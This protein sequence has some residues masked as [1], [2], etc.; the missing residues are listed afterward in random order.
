MLKSQNKIL[1][2]SLRLNIWLLASLLL[3]SLS[4][5][6]V[7]YAY[8]QSANQPKSNS[9]SPKTKKP[10]IDESKF[11]E[12][13]RV[14]LEISELKD[15]ESEG[16]IS[17]FT[18]VEL[19]EGSDINQS[20]DN[21]YKLD[22][23][24]FRDPRG[25]GAQFGTF[26]VNPEE[27]F[28]SYKT[29]FVLDENSTNKR[30]HVIEQETERLAEIIKTSSGP[31][32]DGDRMTPA[33]KQ[34]ALDDLAFSIDLGNY[35]TA[36]KHALLRQTF[37]APTNRQKRDSAFRLMIGLNHRGSL[38][39]YKI[40]KHFRDNLYSSCENW[41]VCY[42]ALSHLG[43]IANASPSLILDEEYQAR[44]KS[45][46]EGLNQKDEFVEKMLLYRLSIIT[47][48]AKFME[49]TGLNSRH[50]LGREPT[51]AYRFMNEDD[52][53]EQ[54]AEKSE[55]I[56]NAINKAIGENS[57]YDE[58][59][60]ILKQ[61]YVS[62]YRMQ[63]RIKKSNNQ[64]DQLEAKLEEITNE[65]TSSFMELVKSTKEQWE[66]NGK[67]EKI[68][69]PLSSFTDSKVLI[70]EKL[71]LI[72][73]KV[74]QESRYTIKN[75]IE[76]LRNPKI[77]ITDYELIAQGMR[78]HIAYTEA[79]RL[80]QDFRGMIPDKL[81][82][83][84]NWENEIAN[85]IQGAY[86][87]SKLGNDPKYIYAVEAMPHNI[88]QGMLMSKYNVEGMRYYLKRLESGWRPFLAGVQKLT[89]SIIEN[90]YQLKDELFKQKG[91]EPL[92]ILF[93]LVYYSKWELS[94]GHREEWKETAQ[95]FMLALVESSKKNKDLP[96]AKEMM[97]M[98]NSE[99]LVKQFGLLDL[100]FEHNVSIVEKAIDNLGLN[101]F[102]GSPKF[103][104]AEI[105]DIEKWVNVNIPGF[106]SI[107]YQYQKIVDIQTR[108][109]IELNKM[110]AIQDEHSQ[111]EVAE[112]VMKPLMRSY[113]QRILAFNCYG[114]WMPI[115]EQGKLITN[116]KHMRTFLLGFDEH[117]KYFESKHDWQRY[118]QMPEDKDGERFIDKKFD[119]AQVCAG[120]T[121]EEK[122]QLEKDGENPLIHAMKNVENRVN[123]YLSYQ[124]EKLF[125]KTDL[126]IWAQQAMKTSAMMAPVLVAMSGV[127]LVN[128]FIR[129]AT[130]NTAI[131]RVSGRALYKY[132]LQ[133]PMN[134]V[135]RTL[136]LVPKII[137]RSGVSKKFMY[138]FSVKPAMKASKWFSGSLWNL[139]L[140]MGLNNATMAMIHDVV[141]PVLEPMFEKYGIDREMMDAWFPSHKFMDWR[142]NESTWQN[143]NRNFGASYATGL[144]LFMA[145]PLFHGLALRQIH[146][147][148]IW[149]RAS[150][151]WYG[152]GLSRRSIFYSQ[153]KKMKL[154][155][156]GLLAKL[157]VNF[158][159]HPNLVG[160]LEAQITHKGF[161]RLPRNGTALEFNPI[162]LSTTEHVAYASLP[163]AYQFGLFLG[164]PY[165]YRAAMKNGS[166]TKEK[167]RAFFAGE[168]IDESNFLD[169]D[170]FQ[171][172]NVFWK[173]DVI[174]SATFTG[175]FSLMGMYSHRSTRRTQVKNIISGERIKNNNGQDQRLLEHYRRGGSDPFKVL[176]LKKPKPKAVK[177]AVKENTSIY[178]ETQIENALYAAS[179]TSKISTSQL[180]KMADIMRS[181][182]K[183]QE[184]MTKANQPSSIYELFGLEK[185]TLNELVKAENGKMDL[186]EGKFKEKSLNDRLADA[187]AY[188]QFSF[189]NKT[190]EMFFNHLRTATPIRAAGTKIEMPLYQYHMGYKLQKSVRPVGWSMG[191][192]IRRVEKMGSRINQY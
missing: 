54:I 158:G 40:A 59:I 130:T 80:R 138:S 23:A 110:Q 161:L 159:R 164:T 50:S 60:K 137:G 112:K 4:F 165:A 166:I 105:M 132:A 184:Y 64:A 180:N 147:R 74:K 58:M 20:Q 177:K 118:Y 120:Y 140:F 75:E 173:K 126:L 191:R 22:D 188:P 151:T 47:A 119:L 141:K 21:I 157:D 68:E 152:V 168:A 100:K 42:D 28:K 122:A 101:V 1:R 70:S 78:E 57:Y 15:L 62:H 115:G 133:H 9:E 17:H 56:R 121:L 163:A 86:T 169:I 174:Q 143:F 148:N 176:K 49:L 107:G 124:E 7:P 63:E 102:Q 150:T 55:E 96:S 162:G 156:T 35:I 154:H 24:L 89:G 109:L 97:R 99:F 129:S 65:R 93:S 36:S 87:K 183:L 33:K 83:S 48:Q 29:S 5:I 8:S 149:G 95:K 82:N 43:E 73:E 10:K 185:P 175:V 31:D 170:V 2:E 127:S 186:F 125:P 90:K 45:L 113:M 53:K 106:E 11:N 12:L 167:L 91:F 171:G 114:F 189:T 144:P 67:K 34:E 26:L 135:R 142:K 66:K 38:N 153:L 79:G 128:G 69:I 139:T 179:S 134:R 76:A 146:Y 116:P 32:D 16:Q 13:L 71:E 25:L 72:E 131:K 81:L 187:L 30:T 3:T 94:M 111:A 182:A 84:D 117:R 123:A 190:I 104:N 14:I 37:L 18:M 6:S 46:F 61:K 145:I 39:V 192:H 19:N 155:N 136:N 103:A 178:S 98:M 172:W 52:K 88:A 181:P 44:L 27:V 51:L 92:S 160:L 108:F 85:K 77:E 41:M